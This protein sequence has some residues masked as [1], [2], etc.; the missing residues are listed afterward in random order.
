MTVTRDSIV[1]IHY[2]LRDDA[3]TIIDS[4]TSGEPLAYLHGH[5]NLVPGLER[6]LAGKNA[7]DKLSVKLAAAD[8]YGEYDKQLVQQVLGP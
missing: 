8:G 2:T 6:E 7:G 4:S 5:G 1:T 3:G